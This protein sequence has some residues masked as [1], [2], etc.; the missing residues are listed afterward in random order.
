[1]EAPVAMVSGPCLPPLEEE[2]E[3]K[4]CLAALVKT[5]AKKAV[6]AVEMSTTST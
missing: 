1:M 6:R 4:S 5:T 3:T 2:D